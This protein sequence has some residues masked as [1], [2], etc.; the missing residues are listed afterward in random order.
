MSGRLLLVFG[1]VPIAV[2][3]A[4]AG[5]EPLIISDTPVASVVVIPDNATIVVR[6]SVQLTATLFDAAGRI[7]IGRQI[8]WSSSDTMVAP[9]SAEGVVK[10]LALGSVNITATSEGHTGTAM[11]RIVLVFRSLTA[12]SSHACGVTVTGAAYCWGFN[13]F[14]QLG[15]GSTTDKPL[16]TPVLG[17]L[18]F[19]SV[20]AGGTH[21]CGVTV[22]GAA[23]C[24]GLGPLGTMLT[25]ELA[26]TPTEV[27]SGLTFQSVSTGGNHTCGVT[28]DSVAYCW[29]GNLFGQLGDGTTTDKTMPTPVVGGLKFLSVSAGGMNNTCGI[30]TTGVAYCWGRNDWGQLGSTRTARFRTEPTLVSGGLAFQSISSGSLHTCAVTPDGLAY[31]WGNNSIGQI[32]A[33]NVFGLTSMPVRVSGGLSFASVSAGDEHSC[34]VT[35]MGAGYCWGFNL[36][37]QLGNG[38]TAYTPVRVP[39]LVAGGLTFASVSA[40]RGSVRGAHTC[41]ITPGGLAYCWGSNVV[42]QLGDGS[43][44]SSAVPVRV[45][46]Q[47]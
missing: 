36:D 14:G 7:L 39:T 29:G 43:M 35:T 46:G 31:C 45:G 23:Y 5:R 6:D 13:F 11:V 32:G 30:T 25:G 20:S 9:V 17:G 15:D 42:G 26:T 8:T 10:G 47:P 27:S 22:T 4:C 3:F 19:Q 28:T 16:P 1:C 41:G 12:G 44:V 34:G 2:S 38:M 18:T 21:T 37:G 33:S 24:W 40:G